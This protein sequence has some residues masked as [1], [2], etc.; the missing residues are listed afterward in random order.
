MTKK[1]SV[2]FAKNPS[3]ILD[4]GTLKIHLKGPSFAQEQYIA[5]PIV[6]ARSSLDNDFKEKCGIEYVERVI[7]TCVKQVDGVELEEVETTIVDGEEVENATTRD[8]VLEFVDEAK[9]RITDESFYILMK[10]IAGTPEVISQVQSFYHKTA[11]VKVSEI[12]IEDKKK[13]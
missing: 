2:S 8:F 1:L 12:E 3:K 5:V 10:V 13:E 6:Q 7:K 9:S 4:F 11:F